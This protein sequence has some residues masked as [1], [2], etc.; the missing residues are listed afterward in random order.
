LFYFHFCRTDIWI[1]GLEL[2]RQVLGVLRPKPYSQ[3]YFALVIFQIVSHDY[4]WGCLD[5]DPLSYL[6]LLHS[7]NDRCTLPCSAFLLVE[8]ESHELFC[9]DW[10]GIVYF[11]S[12]ASWV[13]R[14]TGMRHH[15]QLEFPFW[16]RMLNIF[17]YIFWPF[18]LLLRNVC[19]T[20]LPIY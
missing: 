15:T 18:V 10:P 11:L 17:S 13:V 12:S 8:V 5:C 7:W 14:I 9:L 3:P 2:A 19:S 4:V 6:C 20:H 1:Q 16:L